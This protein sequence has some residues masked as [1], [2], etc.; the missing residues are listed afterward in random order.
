[1]SKNGEDI[2]GVDIIPEELNFGI[3]TNYGR[4]ENI[5]YG[6]VKDAKIAILDYIYMKGS[7]DSSSVREQTI[8]YFQCSTLRVPSFLL[9]PERILDKITM[10]ITNKKELNF[11]DHPE[12][13]KKYLLFCED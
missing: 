2:E 9:R 1:M 13:S 8:I 4:K 10:T 12:L 11:P 7:G 6:K 3:F 5:L